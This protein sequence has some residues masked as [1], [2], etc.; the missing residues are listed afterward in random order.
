MPELE[1]GTGLM[2]AWGEAGALFRLAQRTGDFA[3]VRAL[4]LPGPDTDAHMRKY[5]ALVLTFFD[6]FA[7]LGK[8]ARRPPR[9][10]LPKPRPRPRQ[11]VFCSRVKPERVAAIRRALLDGWSEYKIRKTT[12]SGRPTILRVRAQLQQE[13]A[14]NAAG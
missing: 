13:Q 1:N 2:G 4:I 10:R 5:R 11:R 6:H 14:N 12:G 7:R 8:V 3:S 9:L